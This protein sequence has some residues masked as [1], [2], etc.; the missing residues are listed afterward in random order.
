MAQACAGNPLSMDMDALEKSVDFFQ[1]REHSIIG[2]LKYVMPFDDDLRKIVQCAL[3]AGV[4]D[5]IF[6]PFNIQFEHKVVMSCMPI[7]LEDI[8]KCLDGLGSFC[9]DACGKKWKLGWLSGSPAMV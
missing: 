6:N 7:L 8:G 2:W 9:A 3:V 4:D 1:H 5:I